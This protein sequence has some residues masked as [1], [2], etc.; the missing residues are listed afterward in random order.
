MERSY[1]WS[2]RGRDILTLLN[3]VSHACFAKVLIGVYFSE[4]NHRE[5]ELGMCLKSSGNST[6][7]SVTR[8]QWGLG[9]DEDHRIQIST[10]GW[11]A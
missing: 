11:A 2:F 8:E 1:G 10:Q 5:P 3:V 7:T 9:W 6:E 4:G